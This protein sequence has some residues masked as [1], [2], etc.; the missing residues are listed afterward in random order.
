MPELNRLDHIRIVRHENP[1]YVGKTGTVRKQI[2]RGDPQFP[3]WV[4]VKINGEYMGVRA[5]SLEKISNA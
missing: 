1:K 3:Q 4:Q 2:P 5:D